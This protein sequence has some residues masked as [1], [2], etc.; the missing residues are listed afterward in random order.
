M[1]RKI[2]FIGTRPVLPMKDGRTVLI[3]QYCSVFAS[4]LGCDVFY[5]CFG[6]KE[7]QP[8]YFSKVYSLTEPGFTEQVWH[9]LWQAVI[10]RKWPLQACAV[11][12]RKAQK[13][14]DAA[15][16]EIKPDIIIC[17]MI[18]TAPYLH[19]RYEGQCRKILD[20]DDLLSKR[21]ERQAGQ[22]NADD[23]ALGQLQ[24]RLP[25]L[26]TEMVARLHMMKRLLRM[27][28]GLMKKYERTEAKEFD[29][30]FFCSPTDAAQY[31][32]YAEKKA[33]CVHTA[34]DAD[35]FG[36]RAAENYQENVIGYLGNID[37]SANK[38]SLLYLAERIMPALLAKNPALRLLVIG[39]CSP[40]TYGQFQKYDFMDFTFRV[41]DIRSYV[42]SCMAVVVPLLYGSG[43]KI[44]IIESMAMGVPVITNRYGTEGLDVSNFEQLI[45]CAE[46][47]EYVD[48][49]M[50][51]YGNAALRKRIAQNAE[52]YVRD[53]H[54]MRTCEKE[55]KKLIE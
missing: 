55:L 52:R 9:A 45:E 46:D 37:I 43:I 35:Y 18:R 53:Y 29:R 12:S 13:E 17:D 28:A 44:K 48:A 11:Y 47:C 42:K 27:E 6:L 50:Q 49:V 21:Y 38:D 4:R 14:L 19:G 40:R 32:A 24:E 3:N 15:V 7:Q 16:A 20:M 1:K 8:S 39:N 54:S 5:A 30:V 2:L 41:E 36:E 10:R 33:L 26:V 23:N 51:L 25:R 34:V 31:N 22:K